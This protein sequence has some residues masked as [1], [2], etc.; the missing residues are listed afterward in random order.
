MTSQKTFYKELVSLALPITIQSLLVATLGIADVMMVGSLGDAAVAAVGLASKMHFVTILLVFGFSNA[1]NVLVSQY[2]GAEQFHKIKQVLMLTILTGAG[3]LF[4]VVLLFGLSP[5]SWLVYISEDPDVVALTGEFL[6]ITAAVVV[7]MVIIMTY[8]TVLRAL[9]QTTVPLVVAAI[10]IAMNILLNYVLIFGKWGAPA[11]GVAG[12]A[13]ATLL[14]R[15]LHMVLLL[16]YLKFTQ[17][18]IKLHIADAKALGNRDAWM[19]FWKFA[20]PV[21]FNFVLWGFGSSLYH[22][23]ASRM[24]TEPLA[25]MS[26]LVPIEGII[27]SAFIGFSSAASIF[28]GR[29]LGADDFEYAWK[30]KLFFVRY[31]VVLGVAAGLIMWLCKPFILAPF[32]QLDEQTSLVVEQAFL[33]MCVLVWIKVHNMMSMVSVLRAGGDTIWCLK[34]DVTSLWVIGLPVTALA[35]LYFDLP[36]IY[37]YAIMFVEEAVKLVGSHWR[38][39]QKKWLRNLTNIVKNDSTPEPA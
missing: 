7:I 36:F 17:Y 16:C 32:N 34:I 37:V 1:C 11:L 20:L 21:G 23:I 5:E 29:A 14:S 9:G 18:N 27:I 3:L 12:A 33:V 13:W 30:L 6:A 2:V 38:M 10:A 19:S 31:A 15:L 24:G 8:E 39:Y 35:G 25:V 22:V 26:V 28:L 4:P